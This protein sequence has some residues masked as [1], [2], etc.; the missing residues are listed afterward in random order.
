MAAKDTIPK[1]LSKARGLD[2]M[3][4]CALLAIACIQ[5]GEI[6]VMHHYLGLY[7]ALVAMDGLHDE[8]NWPKGIGIV[9]T[10]ERRRL[11]CFH[12]PNGFQTD[13]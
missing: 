9:E 13:G 1:D 2:Y 5:N 8:A 4:A 10:E 7:H 3:R 11:V 12:S 6:R